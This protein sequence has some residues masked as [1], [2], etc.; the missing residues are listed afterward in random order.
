MTIIPRHDV[1]PF[2]HIEGN[3]SMEAV[4]T[5]RPS[6]LQDFDVTVIRKGAGYSIEVDKQ[7]E[8]GNR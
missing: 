4:M 1:R 5:S 8:K 2:G 3:S 7:E 6:F